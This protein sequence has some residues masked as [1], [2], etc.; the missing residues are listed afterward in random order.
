MKKVLFLS[1]STGGGHNKAAKN[2]MDKFEEHGFEAVKI[3]LLKDSSMVLDTIVSDGYEFLA[4]KMPKLYGV[5]YKGSNIKSFNKIYKHSPM[6]YYDRKMLKKIREI[7]PD[8]IVGTHAFAV[9]LVTKLKHKGKLDTKF[10]SIITDFKAHSAYVDNTVDA[11]ITGSQ[12]TKEDLKKY[13]IDE[14]KIYPYG[15]PISDDFY[16]SDQKNQDE[17]F[18]ILVMGGSMGMNGIEEVVEQLDS[19]PNTLVNVVC[20]KN[21]SLKKHLDKKFERSIGAGRVTIYGFTDQIP[22]LM[23]QCD[24]I[25]TKPG[26]LT[27]TE[28]L[29]KKIPMIIPF[30]IP[31]QEYE[32]LDFLVEE[33]AAIYLSDVSKVDLVVKELSQNENIYNDMKESIAGITAEY[34]MESIVN[35]SKELMM[36]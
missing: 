33:G 34:S 20:G 28:A 24:V 18:N 5:I 16:I 23:D 29:V 35:V 19:L 17:N 36:G 21:K 30:A 26:G 14:D 3:D 22:V 15:I 12:Y 6:D 32:N 8:I 10:I 27:T 9:A 25:I 7:N 31:G 2:L 11:Y 4:M 1:A 13:N